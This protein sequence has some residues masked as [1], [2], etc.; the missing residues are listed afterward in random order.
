MTFFLFFIA[1]K[2]KDMPE[3]SRPRERLLK[4]GP[5]A[6]SNAELLAIILQKGTKSENIIDISNRLLKKGIKSLSSMSLAELQKIKGVGKAKAM[7]IKALFE[8]A[9]RYR[10]EPQPKKISCAKDVFLLMKYLK[11]K[12]KEHFFGIYL[13][14]KNNIIEK[15]ELISVGILDMSVVHPREIF[16]EAIKKASKSIIIVHNHP[17]GI[18]EPSKEDKEITF[19]IYNAGKILGISLL[20]HVIIGRTYFSFR[21]NRLLG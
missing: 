1:M 3:E 14:A 9:S 21:E 18:P 7:Q 2:I 11:D 4:K 10:E 12:K 19:R 13:D 15:P 6:L 20:D 17:S 5:H 8:L 16:I